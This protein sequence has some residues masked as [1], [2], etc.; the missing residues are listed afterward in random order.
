MDYSDN[1]TG[2]E[3]RWGKLAIPFYTF[4]SRMLP[5]VAREL[6]QHPGGPTAQMVRVG[7]KSDA[8][9]D[10]PE[11]MKGET[12]I[13]VGGTHISGLGLMH[14]GDAT[15][16]IG[17]ALKGDLPE[18]ARQGAMRLNP[19]I[20]FPIE[21]ATQHDL[22]T[23]KALDSIHDVEDVTGQPIQAAGPIGTLAEHAVRSSPVARYV[24]EAKK[25]QQGRDK[26]LKSLLGV[27]SSD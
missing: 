11:W 23:G 26:A 3:K 1:L 2:F 10:K 18:L 17:S 15:K 9:S 19:L 20:K 27:K 14:E 6:A 12:S 25:L 24:S 5:L 8:S 13:P 21:Q 22:R 4:S 7:S 16:L